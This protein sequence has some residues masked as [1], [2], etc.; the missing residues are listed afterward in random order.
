MLTF[1]I[2]TPEHPGHI[3][4]TGSGVGLIQYFGPVP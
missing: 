3:R 4:T 2:D 1:A